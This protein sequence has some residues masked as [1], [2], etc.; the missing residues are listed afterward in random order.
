MATIGTADITL[1]ATNQ[2]IL[3]APATIM[4]SKVVVCNTDA[5]PR[6]VTVHKVPAAGTAGAGNIVV[7]ALSLTAG[8]TATLPL[9]GLVLRMADSLQGQAS[10]TSVVNISVGFVTP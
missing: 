2:P 10:V 7:D 8:Q 4:L 1:T 5:S 3:T 9:S 6:T